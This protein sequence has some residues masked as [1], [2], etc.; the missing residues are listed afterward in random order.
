MGE[1]PEVSLAPLLT[2]LEKLKSSPELH[3]EPGAYLVEEAGTAYS[4]VVAT[5]T[6]G[7][8]HWALL[9]VGANFLVPLERAHFSVTKDDDVRQDLAVH[10]GGP[11]CFEADVIAKDQLVAVAPG[12][13]VKI[14]RCGAYTASM[15]S[16]FFSAPPPVFWLEHGHYVALRRQPSTQASFLLYHG[17]PAPTA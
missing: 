12:N 9:D 2:N 17:Y 14:S 15:S 10:F 1:P 4:R 5:K 16:C 6:V 7:S 8:A 11:F 3:L 13:I